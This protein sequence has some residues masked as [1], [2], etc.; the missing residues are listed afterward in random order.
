MKIKQDKKN[1]RKHGDKNKAMIRRSLEECGA[2]RSILIDNENTAIAGNGV[3]EQAEKLGIPIRVVESNGSELI[4]VKRTG[5]SPDDPKRKELAL[6]DNATTDASEWDFDAMTGD[7]WTADDL[8][9]WGV[10]VPEA[11]ESEQGKT[12][13][14]EV[15]DID[16]KEIFSKRGEVYSLGSHRLMCGDSTDPGDVAALMAGKKASFVFTDPPWNVNYGAVESGNPQGYKPRTILNDFMGTEDFKN[17][18]LKA[19]R[20]MKDFSEPGA[21]IYVVMSAQEWG[22]M[23]LTLAMNDF[24]WSST[25]IWNKDR[26]VLSRKDYHTKYEPIW[27]GWREGKS[28]LHPL[29]DR[30]QCDVWDIPRPSK[31]DDHPTMKPVELV[32]RAIENSSNKGDNVLDLFGG[33]GTTLIACEKSGRTGFSMELD[34]KYCDVIRRRWTEFKYGAGCDWIKLTERIEE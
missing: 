32:V 14:D 10:E 15:P 11:F 3:L 21:M 34:P 18:M 12:E 7:G 4:G 17:F 23:M 26:A 13:P 31:S 6:A 25:I 5:L 27:Y 22:N 20:N 2:G 8:S 16:E 9:E 19:F 28:R 24:H 1:Y 33:S 29:T 30:K